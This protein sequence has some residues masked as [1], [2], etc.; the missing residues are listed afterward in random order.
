[1][2]KLSDTGKKV[3]FIML[4][5]GAL[6]I[7]LVVYSQAPEIK[8]FEDCV[9]AGNLVMESYPRQCKAGNEIFV[10]ETGCSC[11]EGYIQEG[12]VCTPECYYSEPPCLA[13]SI[14]CTEAGS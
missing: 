2:V 13:P 12:T 8:S 1:M 9:R 6:V 3:F 10:E 11:H 5:V 4:I 14:P 7:F